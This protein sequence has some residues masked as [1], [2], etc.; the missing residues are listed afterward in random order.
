MTLANSWPIVVAFVLPVAAF[1][2][3]V[4]SDRMKRK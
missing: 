4:F 3:V 2:Y 1:A